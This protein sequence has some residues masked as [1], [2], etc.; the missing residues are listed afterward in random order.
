MTRKL[1]SDQE[2]IKALFWLNDSFKRLK[3]S[4]NPKITFERKN[5]LSTNN[6]WITTSE[7]KKLNKTKSLTFKKQKTGLFK[8]IFSPLPKIN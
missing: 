6:T 1:I 5:S 4:L 2:K 8:T 3:S 7:K